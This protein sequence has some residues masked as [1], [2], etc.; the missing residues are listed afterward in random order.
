MFNGYVKPDVKC[1]GCHN[2]DASGANGPNLATR[3]P[4]LSDEAILKAIN[5][6]PSYMPS[7]KDKLTEDEKQSLVTWL[8]SRFG[9][10]SPP[11]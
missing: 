8:R 3:I 1:F 10:G 5:D 2:G 7:F 9:G 11:R 4:T 6:G